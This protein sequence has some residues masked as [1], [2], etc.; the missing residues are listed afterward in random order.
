[1]PMVTEPE[2]MEIMAEEEAEEKKKVSKGKAI[3]ITIVFMLILLA[4]IIGA[5]LWYVDVNYLWC[6]FF[7][8]LIEVSHRRH[9]AGGP[10]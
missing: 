1:M 10:A 5:F 3:A 2:P 7:G 8:F 4:I 9:L 6:D